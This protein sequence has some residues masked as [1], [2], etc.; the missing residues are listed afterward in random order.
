MPFVKQKALKQPQALPYLSLVVGAR[1]IA[2]REEAVLQSLLISEFCEFS[3]EEFV[4]ESVMISLKKL[5][6]GLAFLEPEFC[7]GDIKLE[8]DSEVDVEELAS[9]WKWVL[10]LAI[11]TDCRL[12]SPLKIESQSWAP[13]DSM[14][15]S[16]LVNNS[17]KSE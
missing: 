1:V 7:G 16:G 11:F 4:M 8:W 14:I 15:A 13:G 3:K 17:E 2:A 5:L 6:C 12:E 10:G 9:D